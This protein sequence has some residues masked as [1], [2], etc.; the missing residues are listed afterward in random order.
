MKAPPEFRGEKGRLYEA[1]LKKVQDST[2][3]AW[4]VRHDSWVPARLQL[5]L[6]RCWLAVRGLFL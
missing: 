2:D 3:A 5:I 1:A 4:L 6:I